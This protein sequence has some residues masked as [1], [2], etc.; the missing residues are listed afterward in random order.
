MMPKPHS[1]R[2]CGVDARHHVQR[3]DPDAGWHGWTEPTPE[4]L[5]DRMRA[6]RAAR[7]IKREKKV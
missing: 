3:W 7:K 6:L 1:C 5:L 2:H 4:Q